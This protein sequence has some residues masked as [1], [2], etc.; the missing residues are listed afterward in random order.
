MASKRKFRHQDI[1]VPPAGTSVR[2]IHAG[3]HE[4]RIAFPKGARRKGSGKIVSILH[5]LGEKNPECGAKLSVVEI[6]AL[7]IP[8]SLNDEFGPAFEG[9]LDE[10]NPS[11]IKAKWDEFRAK[12]AGWI[13]PHRRGAETQSNPTGETIEVK[14]RKYQITHSRTP[15]QHEAEGRASLAREMRKSGIVEDMQ[16]SGKRGGDFGAY[17]FKSGQVRFYYPLYKNPKHVAKR[18]YTEQVKTSTGKTLF[19]DVIQ[20]GGRWMAEAYP[21]SGGKVK[22]VGRPIVAHGD[23]E[24]RAY[25]ALLAKVEPNPAKRKGNRKSK[26]ENRKSGKRKSKKNVT[27]YGVV[28]G[29]N[30]QQ[31]WYETASKDAGV[32]T[33]E[34][35][36]AGFRVST[37]G[38]GPQVTP[39]GTVKMTLLSIY[40]PGDREI[41]PPERV[42]RLNPAIKKIWTKSPQRR[43][44]PESSRAHLLPRSGR[45]SFL[46][47][48]ATIM[49]T[50]AG[51]INKCFIRPLTARNSIC[52]ESPKS[53]TGSIKRRRHGSHLA[54]DCREAW[55]SPPGIRYD[56]R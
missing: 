52:P 41:P 50:W 27:A 31:E 3:K 14:G 12:V 10:Q 22:R 30:F 51:S 32:R 15:D 43:S 29:A 33:R 47:S 54:R 40:S 49:R 25:D 23:T 5:P 8:V 18:N 48:S 38:M 56:R 28:R 4:V 46:T 42:E 36:K 1:A 24:S 2:T 11:R 16:L 6:A 20:S 26:I 35:R 45:S 44:W 37:Q 7:E 53:T 19:V 9:T 17:R 13:A 34:L 21:V 39:V 55:R